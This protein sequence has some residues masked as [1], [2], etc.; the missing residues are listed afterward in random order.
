MNHGCQPAKSIISH[1]VVLLESYDKMD[2]KPDAL[3]VIILINKC[4]TLDEVPGTQ[5]AFN[6]R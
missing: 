3:R 4:E 5:K 1:T 2:L 6:K